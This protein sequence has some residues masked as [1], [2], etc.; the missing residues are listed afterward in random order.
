MAIPLT[1]LPSRI[2]YQGTFQAPTHSS[3]P[4]GYVVTLTGQGVRIQVYIAHAAPKQTRVFEGV[5]VLN[6]PI[7]AVRWDTPL[8]YGHPD[9]ELAAAVVWAI[10]KHFPVVRQA[11]TARKGE[12]VC[13]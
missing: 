11:L 5:M 9:E 10:V 4:G 7:V 8:A 3:L 6:G 13:A 2:L 1:L 12:T